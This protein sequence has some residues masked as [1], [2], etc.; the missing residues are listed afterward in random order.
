MI[1]CSSVGGDWDTP[2]GVPTE[3]ECKVSVEDCGNDPEYAETGAIVPA[4]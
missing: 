1:N 4:F 2:E 3:L